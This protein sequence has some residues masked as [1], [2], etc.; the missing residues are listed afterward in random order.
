MT[1][2]VPAPKLLK[3]YLDD[4]T[5]ER[6]KE[7]QWYLVQI[8]TDGSRPIP[9]SKLEK[10]TR[11]ETVNKLVEAFGEDG[12]VEWTVDTFLRM[13][14]NDLASKLVQAK[15]DQSLEQREEEPETSSAREKPRE[16]PTFPTDLSCSTCLSLFTDPVVLQCGHSFCQSCVH[17]YW[18]KNSVRECSLCKQLIPEGDPPIN[19][20]L[21]SLCEKYGGRSQGEPP[22]GHRNHTESFQT[23]PENIREKQEA[24]KNVKQLCDSSVEHIKTQSFNTENKIMEIFNMLRASLD[25]E[26]NTRQAALIKEAR[27]KI[28]M[29]HLMHEKIKNTHLLSHT[30]GEIE[31]LAADKSIKWTSGTAEMLRMETD[32]LNGLINSQAQINVS[33]HVENLPLT[34]L[35]KMWNNIKKI[36]VDVDPKTASSSPSPKV[37]YTWQLCPGN[38][39]LRIGLTTDE[40]EDQSR[41]FHYDNMFTIDEDDDQSRHSH[42]DYVSAVDEDQSRHSHYDYVSAVDEDQSRHSHYDYVSAVDE[43]QSRRSYYDYLS[44]EDE[45]EDEDQSRHSH[46][47]YVSAVD[48]DEDQSRHSHYD[49]VSAVDEDQSRRSY[50]DYLS[51]ED[52]DEDEDQSRHSHYDYVSAVGEDQSRHSHYDY[53]SA[54]DEDQSRRS[55]YDYLSDEDEDEDED[56]SRHSHYDYVSAVDEDEDQSRH[57]HYDYVSAVDEDQSR[58][59]YYDYLSDEDE[60]EDEDQSRHSHYDYVS[61]VDEDQSRRSYYDYLSDEDEDEDEDEDQSRHSHYDYVSA[62]DEDQSRRSHYDYVSAVDEDEDQSRHSHYDYVSAVDEDQSRRSYYDYVS[63][64]DEDQSRRSYYDYVSAVDEDQSRRSYYDYV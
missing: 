35:E 52:E 9:K 59:S 58:R 40:D 49:Y 53:V 41:R 38:L 30:M 10:A 26:E 61:A 13:K 22:G 64:V 47:D 29:M 55:Y 3:E 5:E 18:E 28:R 7:F 51:D 25:E 60:D 27:L 36:S 6:L 1:T 43:D 37:N 4:L 39:C 42:H 20:S 56:Q 19:F 21:K 50:Y 57:S 33:K 2:P 16:D 17:E 23:P 12:A 15:M 63:A 34:V 8:Q 62:V 44:D 14:L 31:N 54:V 46:Y 32:M 45:D 48:E 24:L 11:V